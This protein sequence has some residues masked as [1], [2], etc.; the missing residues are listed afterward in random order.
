[1]IIDDLDDLADLVA[2][3]DGFGAS[4]DAAELL[5]AVKNSS[6]ETP[7]DKALED[8]R[9][10]NGSLSFLSAVHGVLVSDVKAKL[11]E[12][13]AAERKNAGEPAR[14]TLAAVA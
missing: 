6:A 11:E 1:M 10:R 12:I 13:K 4:L 14:P 3:L 7:M 8:F 5:L 9:A 2:R